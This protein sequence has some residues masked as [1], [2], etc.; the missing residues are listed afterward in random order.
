MLPPWAVLR[1]VVNHAAYHRGR[2]SSKLKRFGVQQA[3]T[4]LVYWAMEQVPSGK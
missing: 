2:L 4:E 3:E 1:H